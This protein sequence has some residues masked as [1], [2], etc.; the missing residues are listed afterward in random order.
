[1]KKTKLYIVAV[2]F[3]LLGLLLLSACSSNSIDKESPAPDPKRQAQTEFIDERIDSYTHQCFRFVEKYTL[4]EQDDK[5][6][7]EVSLIP[8]IASRATKEEVYRSLASYAWN[9]NNFFPEIKSYDFTVLWDERQK[10]E[11]I[12]ARIDESGV[13]NLMTTY[14]GVQMDLNNKLDSSYQTVFTEIEESDIVK[15]W[16]KR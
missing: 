16:P 5:Y 13:A 9:V 11:A 6:S 2:L 4:T 14:T 7:I 10:Q 12:H 1:M 3:L 8:E 15:N